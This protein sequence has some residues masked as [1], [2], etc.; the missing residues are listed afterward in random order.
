M[1]AKLLLGEGKP[2]V[3]PS[4]LKAMILKAGLEVGDHRPD[5]GVVVGGDGRFGRYGRTEE[6]P[7]LFVG[8]RAKKGTGSRAFMAAA[9][10]DELPAALE[11]IKAGEFGTEEHRRLEVLKNGRSLGEVF[12]DVYLQRGA[13]S[14][15]IRYKVIATGE[16]ASIEEAAIGDGVIFSTRAGAT[17]YYSYPDRIRG[18]RLDPGA[19]TE[20][21]TGELG[22]CHINPT[23]TE[24]T[25]F[26]GHPLRYKVPWGCTVEAYLFRPAVARLYGTTDDRGGVK[27]TLKDRVRVLPAKRVTKVIR[28]TGAS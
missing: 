1:K 24:R 13:E 4:D 9:Y 18:D 26:E 8:V 6:V 5:L 16:G 19:Y 3:D 20:I 15:C 11:K 28:L 12:T 27:V 22:V 10:Y 14:T 7:L 21:G 25:G 2:R 23:Y 17:G